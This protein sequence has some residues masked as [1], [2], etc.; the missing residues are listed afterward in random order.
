MKKLFF[1][2]LLVKL[3]SASNMAA[4]GC[5]Y[6][7]ISGGGSSFAAGDSQNVYEF[8]ISCLDT[9][10]FNFADL[11]GNHPTSIIEHIIEQRSGSS[12]SIVSRTRSNGARTV[13]R[14]FFPTAIGR[15][16]YRIEN[17]GTAQV[18]HWRMEGRMPLGPYL[19]TLSPYMPLRR[20]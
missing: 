5:S 14:S 13:H 4:A 20:Y 12:W 19:P 7:N 9:V 6:M 16:R 1:S 18:R 3:L 15:Y 8:S 17:V 11:S 10:T 2:L